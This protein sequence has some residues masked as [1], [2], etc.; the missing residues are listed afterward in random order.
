MREPGDGVEIFPMRKTWPQRT[1]EGLIITELFLHLPSICKVYLTPI[2]CL[3][4][5]GEERR[6][7]GGSAGRHGVERKAHPR[8]GG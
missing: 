6:T 2:L 1:A 4:K 8:G 7:E 5:F 3:W